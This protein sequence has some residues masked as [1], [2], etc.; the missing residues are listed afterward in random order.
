M[1]RPGSGSVGDG[2][3]TVALAAAA[4]AFSAVCMHAP[5]RRRAPRQP[6]ANNLQQSTPL[7]AQH[8]PVW[9]CPCWCV[10]ALTFGLNHPCGNGPRRVVDVMRAHVADQA[11]RYP[12]CL[13]SSTPQ[14]LPSP[15]PSPSPAPLPP[16][17]GRARRGRISV[18]R[19]A[20][21][22]RLAQAAAAEGSWT[23]HIMRPRSGLQ[24]C[25][26]RCAPNRC[27]SCTTSPHAAGLLGP[28]QRPHH[29]EMQ[30]HPVPVAVHRRRQCESSNCVS[31]GSAVVGMAAC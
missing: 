16:V 4:A 12:G 25:L 7:C 31:V 27:P 9:Q 10:Q 2:G 24:A 17:S 29:P 1:V 8:P 18:F 6:E 14:P 22:G 3:A 13:V 21:Q 5:L 11:Q 28:A 20:R 23:V 19:M 26:H 30:R 15:K